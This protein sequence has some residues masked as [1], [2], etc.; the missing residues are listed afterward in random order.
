[1][2]DTSLNVLPNGIGYSK[3][4]RRASV[5]IIYRMLASCVNRSRRSMLKSIQ[6]N[7]LEQ[8]T[9][10][11]RCLEMTT[12]LSTMRLALGDGPFP[13][14]DWQLPEL[15]SV[16]GMEPEKRGA[17][18]ARVQAFRLASR[19]ALIS[20]V[21]EHPLDRTSVI[22][23]CTRRTHRKFCFISAGFIQPC[24]SGCYEFN[25]LVMDYFQAQYYFDRM[26]HDELNIFVRV[27]TRWLDLL[28]SLP[29][30]SPRFP[31]A[32]TTRRIIDVMISVADALPARDALRLPY[33]LA[34]RDH[35]AWISA[36]ARGLRLLG[37]VDGCLEPRLR[38][39]VHALESCYRRSALV[40]NRPA[41]E[42]DLH[43]ALCDLHADLS[44]CEIKGC[45]WVAHPC[46]VWPSEDCRLL[47]EDDPQPEFPNASEQQQ[48]PLAP[49]RRA[50]SA[51]P[52]PFDR[53]PSA[54]PPDFVHVP[55]SSVLSLIVPG[56]FASRWADDSSA[57]GGLDGTASHIG[58]TST[59]HRDAALQSVHE[60]SAD[61]HLSRTR[62]DDPVSNSEPQ[63]W[64]SPI[65]AE[66]EDISSLDTP[67]SVNDLTRRDL[68]GAHGTAG[69]DTLVQPTELTPL[70]PIHET[71]PLLHPF[72]T[73]PFSLAEVI[74]RRG[75]VRAG[76]AS[77]ESFTNDNGA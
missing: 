8:L 28:L 45:R 20:V 23:Y 17:V 47:A 40:G 3:Q 48:P 60:P 67:G 63:P 30:Y 56:R 34:S 9:N 55:A 11:R 36:V 44:E 14:K 22:R 66:P 37:R 39:L 19:F 32:E 16:L 6:A 76:D 51:P 61:T 53:Q 58:Q 38:C 27:G 50:R 46:L 5:Y 42:E 49:P 52:S 65:T 71:S 69:S 12:V 77:R 18:Y 57:V 26:S 62:G 75:A 7:D 10:V 54:P 68:A 25:S 21:P 70:P 24:D 41:I 13:T 74:G 4:H 15:S 31:P 64:F 29:M 73:P 1:M 72:D 43:G 2:S 59:N 33:G 35:K